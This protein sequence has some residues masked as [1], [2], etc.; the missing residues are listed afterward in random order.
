MCISIYI[1]IDII[2]YVCIYICEYHVY[3]YIH[4]YVRYK[5]IYTYIF[6]IYIFFLYVYIVILKQIGGL[7]LKNPWFL[8]P[9]Y[10][11]SLVPDPLD[12]IFPIYSR[13]LKMFLVFFSISIL[14]NFNFSCQS[15][16][17]KQLWKAKTSYELG[18]FLALCGQL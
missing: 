1:Y 5:Y 16:V 8:T 7:F 18:R 13:M 14:C 17:V 3:I 11:Y 15:F 2:M 4:I 6:Y 10:S 12:R 9:L